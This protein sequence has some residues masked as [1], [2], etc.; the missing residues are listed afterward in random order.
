M[1]IKPYYN[2]HKLYILQQGLTLQI[3]IIILIIIIIIIIILI[4]IIIII[5]K[6]KKIITWAVDIKN[7][8]IIIIMKYL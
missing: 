4:I 6:F 5:M 3:K 1:K 8:L 2:K 7:K